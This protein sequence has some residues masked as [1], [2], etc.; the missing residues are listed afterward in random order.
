MHLVAP[1]PALAQKLRLAARH[2]GVH[3]HQSVY[4]AA[5]VLLADPVVYLKG[6]VG[7]AA[8]V[9]TREARPRRHGHG[10]YLGAVLVR[11]VVHLGEIGGDLAVGAVGALV[12]ADVV[13]TAEHQHV[14]VMG[15]FVGAASR[16]T[17]VGVLAVHIAD[18][19]AAHLI[20]HVAAHPVTV[21]AALGALVAQVLQ[22]TAAV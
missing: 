17:R 13:D 14:G 15:A 6:R 21:E 5:A 3:I 8:I 4:L 22:V 16:F 19:A 20:D 11:H 2:D 1:P 9:V 18:K 7:A 10:D 12:A